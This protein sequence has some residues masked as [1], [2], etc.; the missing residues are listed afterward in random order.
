[1]WPDPPTAWSSVDRWPNTGAQNRAYEVFKRLDVLD[2]EDS[3]GRG[4]DE[5]GIPSVRFTGE[6]QELRLIHNLG[7][8]LLVI[9]CD[10]N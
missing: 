9:R 5:A 10:A 3:G 6:A 2:S 1:M 4:E 8:Q 7:Q